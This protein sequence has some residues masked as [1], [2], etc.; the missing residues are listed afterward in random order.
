MGKKKGGKSSGFISQGL[1]SN[2]AKSTRRAMRAEYMASGERMINQRK[3]FDAGKNVVVTIENPNKNETNKRF[4]RVN[5][6][7]IWKSNKYN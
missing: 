1:H 3:A 2:V 6:K 7:D 4:I 5:A